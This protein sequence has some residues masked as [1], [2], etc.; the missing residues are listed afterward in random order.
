[1]SFPGKL[2]DAAGNRREGGGT[3]GTESISDSG[4]RRNKH[5]GRNE[6]EG[7]ALCRLGPRSSGWSWN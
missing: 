5:M 7:E 1:M 2:D 6:Q 4:T 3:G